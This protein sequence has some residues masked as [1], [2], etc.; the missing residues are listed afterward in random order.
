MRIETLTFHLRPTDMPDD[1]FDESDAYSQAFIHSLGLKVHSGCWCT[2]RLDSPVIHDF[3]REARVRI[4]RGEATFYGLCQLKQELVEDE[5]TPGEWYRLVSSTAIERDRENNGIET[6]K[7]Y[8]MPPNAHIASGPGYN[9]YVSAK[10]KA[11]VEEY[12]LT[13]IDFVWLKDTGKYRAQQWYIPVPLQP[14]GRGIDHPWFNA[15]VLKGSGSFQSQYPKWRT[16]VWTF[17]INQ[18]K[19]GLQIDDPMYRELFD[20]FM[21]PRAFEQSWTLKFTAAPIYLRSFLPTTDFAYT[22]DDEDATDNS[23]CPKMRGFCFNRRAKDILLT[24]RLV[25]EKDIEMLQIVDVVPEGSTLLDGDTPL[26]E[27]YFTSEEVLHLTQI[28]A[29]DWKR[30]LVTEKPVRRVTL[31]EALK[32]VRTEKAARKGDFQRGASKVALAGSPFP[33]PGAWSVLLALSNGCLLNN[34]CELLP[35]GNIPE[36][37][38]ELRASIGGVFDEYPYERPLISVG[39]GPDGDWYALEDQD[40]PTEDSRV[41]RISH[42]DFS[43]IYCWET[44]PLFIN[45]MLTGFYE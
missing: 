31:N 5:K 9:Q 23:Y 22:W 43:I 2:V 13:G 15:A 35:V 32:Y 27:P 7:A 28:L 4:T 6:C 33:L 39:Y 21:L 10:S 45:D 26:P 38:N 11:V 16:G 40:G 8:K 34:E 14:L 36:R 3:I 37:T 30:F 41:F 17:D 20:L 42:E 12:R 18:C 19:Q 25:N 1:A 29:P 24:H 44:I